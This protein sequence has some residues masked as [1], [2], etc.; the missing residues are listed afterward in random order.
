LT[1]NIELSAVG[2]AETPARLDFE[3]LFGA[4]PSPYM[5]LDRRFQYV[6]V[7]DAYV[8][9]TGRSRES[10]IGGNLF[11][12]FPND[13]E[14]GALLRASLERVL[15]TGGPDSIAYIPYPIRGLNG[16]LEMRYWSAVHTPL[17][18]AEGRV[19]F[20]VQN[21]VDVTE[22]RQL[23]DIAYGPAGKPRASAAQLLLRAQEVQAANASLTHE[24]NQLRDLFMQAPGFMAVLTGREMTFQFVN[25]AY[26]QLIGHRQVIGR[27]VLEALP[28]VRAQ[29]FVELLS[30]VMATGRPYVGRAM[31]VR[32]Q[33]TP[34]GPPQERFVDFIYQPITDPAGE[35]TGVFVE[36]YDVTDRV[37]AE[38]QQKLLVDE[39]NHR[40]KNTLATVQAIAAQTL[41]GHPEPADFREQFEAR[42]MALSGTHD[43]LTATSW[44]SACLKDV[45]LAELKP[46]GEGRYELDGADLNLTPN[47]ALTL[48]LVFH[49]LATNAAKYG[50]LSSP[51]GSICVSWAVGRK[52]GEARLTLTWTERGGPA[53]APPMRKGFG[54]RLIERTLK[55]DIDGAA[56]LDFAP[57][58]L[59]CRIEAPLP[60]AD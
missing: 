6:A 16:V 13:G 28:E 31:G 5:V 24:T 57:S 33:R 40:V 14:S 25:S 10:L 20:V 60:T 22:L 35:A 9:A 59:V 19:T 49:E 29:G 17:K 42:L 50:A 36:G 43:L 2:S 12:L 46:H 56:S 55:G 3:A 54:S 45:L 47:Q 15:K 32:L 27:T 38:Q 41:R 48:G 30:E 11:D 39:L 4:L 58:G 21:T 37:R 34:D 51:A 8:E 52:D 44:R 18:D 26:L 7:N 23:K 1:T 53:V